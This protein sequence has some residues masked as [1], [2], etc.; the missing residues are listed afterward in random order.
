MTT[1]NFPPFSFQIQRGVW[2]TLCI[3]RLTGRPNNIITDVYCVPFLEARS[4]RPGGQQDWVP[5]R[6]PR[7]R[8]RG[9]FQAPLPASGGLLAI[10]GFMF[11]WPDAWMNACTEEAVDKH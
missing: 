8:G 10:S 4:P 5:L 1:V 9:L 2:V 7:V 3:V 11:T 6:A